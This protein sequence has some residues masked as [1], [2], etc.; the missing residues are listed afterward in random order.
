MTSRNSDKNEQLY[1]VDVFSVKNLD[2]IPYI[3][4]AMYNK[5]KSVIS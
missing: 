2:E 5:L 1:I 3:L 4:W